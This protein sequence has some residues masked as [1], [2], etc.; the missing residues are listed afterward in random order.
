MSMDGQ[1][2]RWRRKIAK[3]FNRVSRVYQRHRQTTNRQTDGR[4][5]IAN[6]NVSRSRSLK[7]DLICIG[8]IV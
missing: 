4:W 1:G 7:T 5:H 3:N 2:T 8:R 6:V